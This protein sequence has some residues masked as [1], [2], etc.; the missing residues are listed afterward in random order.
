M[1]NPPIRVYWHAPAPIFVARVNLA[2][3]VYPIK[4]IPFDGVTVG[5]YTDCEADQFF[6]L[7]SAENLGDLGR[8]RLRAVPTSTTLK[9]GRSSQGFEDGQLSVVDNAWIH[10][11]PDFRVH[12]KIPV[13][14][15]DFI[16]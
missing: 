12:S 16:E 14:G 4:D 15:S 2:S 10:V 3:P 8:G 1:L 7:G 5:A 6:T 13:I 11:Y 9:V